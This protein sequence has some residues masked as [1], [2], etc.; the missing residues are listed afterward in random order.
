[1]PRDAAS[2]ESMDVRRDRLAPAIPAGYHPAWY[3]G[4][5]NLVAAIGIVAALTQLHDVSVWEWL[6]VPAAFLVANWVEYRVHMGPMHHLRPPW[7][8]LFQR[9]V[10]QHHVYFD[11]THMSARM[12]REYY[13]VFFPW[14]AVGMVVLTAALFALPLGLLVSPNAALLFFAVGIA[15]YLTYEWLHLSYHLHPQSVIGRV[16]LV[17]RLRRLHTLHHQTS[18][19]TKR[20]FNITFPICD[21]LFGTLQ[22]APEATPEAVLHTPTASAQTREIG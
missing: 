8:I 4:A 22:T 21:W 17:Q 13:W 18:L 16:R 9:H 6:I 20:N 7:Q 3:F 19:M 5:S 11:D 10:R 12:N 15:Y 14:W 2:S 1:M